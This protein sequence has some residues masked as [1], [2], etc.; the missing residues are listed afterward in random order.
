MELLVLGTF[1]GVVHL[2]FPWFDDRF[3]DQE[4]RWMGFVGGIATGYV[5]LYMLPKISRISVGLI[6]PDID[7]LSVVHMQHYLLILAA[8]V[9]YITM[10]R[11]GNASDQTSIIAN[12]F[13]YT[14]H[15]AYS[16]LIGYVLVEL[17][18]HESVANLLITLILSLHLMG[19]NHLHRRTFRQGYDRVARWIYFLLILL[20]AGLGVFTELP[21]R[22][23]DSMTSFLAGI[24][25]VNVM[26]E[27]LPLGKLDR[28]AWYLIGVGCFI[29]A[30]FATTALVP[31]TA[32]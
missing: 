25:L 21:G 13:H 26:V 6:D 14:V 10:K 12:T 28:L 27:E 19:M 1:L 32:Y 15:G 11:L 2:W 4:T 17:S 7:Y 16:F 5:I 30:T 22:F 8:V 31:V 23:I 29:I 9:I 20:G 3:A 24:I 18:A